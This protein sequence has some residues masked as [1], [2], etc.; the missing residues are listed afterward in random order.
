[1]NWMDQMGIRPELQKEVAHFRERFD[2]D[3]A[4]SSVRDAAEVPRFHYLGK[5]ILEK[6]IC[7]LLCEKNLLLAGPKATGKN[8]LAENLAWIFG[9]PC[10]NVSFHINVDASYLIGTDTFDGEKVVFRPGPVYQCARYGGFGILDE[11][12]MAKNEAMAVLHATLDYRRILEVSGYDR[13]VLHPAARFIGTMNYGYA[14]TRELNEA[15]GSRFLVLQMPT[16]SEKQLDLLLKTEYPEIGRN[17]CRQLSAIFYELDAKAESAEISPRVVDLRGLL[18]AVALM[19]LGLS[20]LDACDMG[21]TN[22]VFDATER[23]IIH[24]V[25]AARIPKS[26]N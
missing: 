21:L 24:D 5:D 22:K 25:I 23:A 4:P 26:W 12:N 7:A 15:L 18:D 9:R 10:W 19:R 14:G 2:K 1:M 8:V 16:I 6:A 13:I 3:T 11:I 17:M 20:P